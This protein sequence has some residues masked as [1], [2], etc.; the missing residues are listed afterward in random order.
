MSKAAVVVLADTETKEDLGRIANALQAV[1]EFTEAGDDVQLIF[2]GAG[3]K[4]VGELSQEGHKYHPVFEQVKNKV[5]GVCEYCAGAFAVED[6]V[7]QSGLPLAT[8]YEGHP[9]FKK[10]VDGGYSVITF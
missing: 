5:T 3:V 10:L 7:K 1:K 6:A 2:D 8:D 9:S 4:W